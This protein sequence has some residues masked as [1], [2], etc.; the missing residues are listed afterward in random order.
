MRRNSRQFLSNAL[1]PQ[2]AQDGL[3]IDHGNITERIQ[4]PNLTMQAAELV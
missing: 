4:T 2:I 3:T 1:A